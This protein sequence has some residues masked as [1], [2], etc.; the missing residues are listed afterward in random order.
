MATSVTDGPFTYTF[1]APARVGQYV[2]GDWWVQAPVTITSITPA[3]NGQLHGFMVNPTFGPNSPIGS[4]SCYH[5][6]HHF[7][8][9][10]CPTLPLVLPN[11]GQIRSIVKTR[12][13]TECTNCWTDDVIG[14]SSPSYVKDA[15]VL[16]VVSNI[17]ATDAFRP[18]YTGTVKVELRESDVDYSIFNLNLDGSRYPMPAATLIEK[19]TSQPWLISD[20]DWASRYTFNIAAQP[21]YGREVS[22]GVN[23]L[24][25]YAIHGGNLPHRNRVR[26]FLVQHGL[27]L[28][29][30]K[31]DAPEAFTGNGG[32]LNGKKLPIVLLTAALKPGALKTY[33]L[34]LLATTEFSED[35]Q[36]R[37]GTP[38]FSPNTSVYWNFGK[39]HPGESLHPTNWLSTSEY[40]VNQMS[41][42]YCCTYNIHG[43]TWLVVSL[44]NLWDVW[45]NDS[46]RRGVWGYYEIEDLYQQRNAMMEAT[47]SDMGTWYIDPSTGHGAHW[48][49]QFYIGEIWD[50]EAAAF[51]PFQ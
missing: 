12:S 32:Q 48:G 51:D 28:A 23:V 45:Q 21:G 43:G 2:T 7:N 19:M 25:L 5:Y 30:M 10:V 18:N 46:F 44:M 22:L 38:Y 16:T 33:L 31:N 13:I 50:L 35:D 8:P 11:D 14:Y 49:S 47:G 36:I 26:R 1:S 24:A 39:G 4:D 29:A 27:D 40:Y 3:F 6:N 15:S 17:P 37:D 20:A 41:Y 34:Y 42:K 9:A